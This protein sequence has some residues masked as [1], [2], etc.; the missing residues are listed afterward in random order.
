M[1]KTWAKFIIKLQQ[2]KGTPQ[3]IALGIAFG[4]SI[5]FT[6]FIGFHSL[7]ACAL[8][9]LFGGN[10]PAALIGT[11]IG[12]PWTFP[13]IWLSTYYFGAL[14]TGINLHHNIN[15]NFYE[16]FKTSTHALLSFDFS[17]FNSDVWPIFYPMLLGCIPF[18]IAVW[19][20]SYYTIKHT[21]KKL[22]TP[23]DIKP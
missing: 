18:C 4:T 22:T 19:I 9:W 1:K 10:I 5:S 20:I 11:L 13:F 15:L 3:S 8:S 6:P 23:K 2:L 12:N 17:Q 21:L 14:I 7:L 16:I